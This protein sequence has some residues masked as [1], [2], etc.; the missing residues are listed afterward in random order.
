[1]SWKM[2]KS[3][4]ESKP[5]RTFRLII[6]SWMYRSWPTIP[7]VFV[8]GNFLGGC[9]LLMEMHSSGDLKALLSKEQ[10]LPKDEA[11]ETK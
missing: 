5:T 1:M 6:D 4:Q 3:A 9:D 8:K 10:I 11:A 2:K 7:Q